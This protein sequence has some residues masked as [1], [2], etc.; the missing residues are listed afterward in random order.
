MEDAGRHRQDAGM[1]LSSAIA[2]GSL[3]NG[4]PVATAGDDARARAPHPGGGAS[5]MRPLRYT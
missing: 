1:V 2:R 3:A 5:L 4:E